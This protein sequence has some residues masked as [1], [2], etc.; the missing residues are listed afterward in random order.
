MGAR[1]GGTDFDQTIAWSAFMP[2]FGKG[3]FLK[4]NLPVPVQLFLDA[5]S[6]RDLPAQIKFR[7]AKYEIGNLMKESQ[8]PELLN[9]LLITQEFQLQ[10]AQEI[11]LWKS[12][13][14]SAGLKDKL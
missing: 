12:L 7:Q 3:S 6:T 13:V 8:K 2:F 14:K 10:L 1:I 11:H 9:R 4:N 5:I